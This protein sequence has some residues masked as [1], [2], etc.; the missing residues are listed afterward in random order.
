M[1]TVLM[2]DNQVKTRQCEFAAIQR[3][4]TFPVKTN[5]ETLQWKVRTHQLRRI[6]QISKSFDYILLVQMDDSCSIFYL[7]RSTTKKKENILK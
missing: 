7:F 4:S 5:L 6:L 3:S 1:I 2:L